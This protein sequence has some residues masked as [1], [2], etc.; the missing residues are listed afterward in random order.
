MATN[1]GDII[2]VINRM[3]KP[4]DRCFFVNSRITIEALQ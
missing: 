2:L 3:I 1:K 4:K